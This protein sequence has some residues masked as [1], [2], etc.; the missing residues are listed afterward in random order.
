M[1]D[2]YTACDPTPDILDRAERA[3]AVL[4]TETRAANFRRPMEVINRAGGITAFLDADKRCGI[5]TSWGCLTRM[6]VGRGFLPG[7]MIVIGA[8]LSIGKTALACQIAD[9]AATHGTGTAFFTLEMPDESIL[10][11]MAAARAQVDS[12]MI[13]QGWANEFER[14]ALSEALADPTDEEICKLWIDDTTGCTVPAMRAALRR[15][16]AKHPIGLVI[17]DYLQLVETSGGSER[18]Y[19]QVTEISRGVKRLA[20]EFN[21]PV[22][23]AQLNR[24]SEK[25]G[26]RN[27]TRVSYATPGRS[28]RMPT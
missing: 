14:R 23:L 15:L 11:R 10:L 21:V 7:Q 3:I 24:E 17:I 12:L 25:P 4:N 6:L 19:E 26:T 9:Y 28:S 2:C 5:E 8:R 22:V 16:S 1:E 13:T 18:R 20:R 27:D